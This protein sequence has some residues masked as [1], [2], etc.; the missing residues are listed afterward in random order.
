MVSPVTLMDTPTPD[1]SGPMEERTLLL[2]ATMESYARG[3]FP[4]ARQQ[5][6]DMLAVYT[7]DLQIMTLLAIIC[8]AQGERAAAAQWIA[9]ALKLD[10]DY[11]EALY[12]Q[13]VL[14]A[15][16]QQ[17]P[18]AID[19]FE[20]AIKHLPAEAGRE[21]AEYLY[22]LGAGNV[23]GGDYTVDTMDQRERAA[24]EHYGG[25]IRFIPFVTGSSTTGIIEKILRL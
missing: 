5:A 1:I 20:R 25:K 6:E 19:A 24:I 16:E 18:R 17:F 2:Q 23:K 15:K 9:A 22:S 13:G 10:A 3:Q 8:D 12:Y 11:P 14:A 4:E 7:Q 21:R